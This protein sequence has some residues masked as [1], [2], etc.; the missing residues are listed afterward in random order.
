ML[1]L[2]F[3]IFFEE[4]HAFKKKKKFFYKFFKTIYKKM[5]AAE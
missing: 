5:N 1:C 3:C 2:N 4:Y